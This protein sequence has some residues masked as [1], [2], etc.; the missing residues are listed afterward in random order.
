MD[1]NSRYYLF[2]LV[3]MSAVIVGLYNL[4]QK[5]KPVK[6]MVLLLCITLA[7]ELTAYWAAVK[8]QNNMFVY[9]I[10]AP[11]QLLILAK[12]FDEIEPY[13]KKQ[14]VGIIVGIVGILG[15]IINTYFYQSINTL[16][17][18]FL[19]FEGL[20]IMG[21]SLYTFRRILNTETINI[22][23]YPYFWFNIILVFFWSVTY[24]IWA[25]YS[26]MLIKKIFLM[27]YIATVLWGVSTISYLAMAVVLFTFSN[28]RLENA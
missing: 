5:D 20:I 25:L 23:R 28:K 2:L 11:V 7:S 3:L 6:I 22:Y 26:V 24:T 19:L 27:P 9:H 17:S 15:T 10:F 12:Y 18:N 4:R 21:L 13:L 1:T 16:N 8:F 14:K